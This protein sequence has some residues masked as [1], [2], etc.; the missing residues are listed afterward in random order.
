M[1]LKVYTSVSGIEN[2]LKKLKEK[3]KISVGV[4]GFNYIYLDIQNHS[5]SSLSGFELSQQLVYWTKQDF[6]RIVL[7]SLEKFTQEELTEKLF[8]WVTKN[9]QKPPL[10]YTSLRTRERR[11]VP[12]SP[13]NVITGEFLKA[14]K[15]GFSK[16]PPAS[17]EHQYYMRKI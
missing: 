16:T 14:I 1:P 8:E 2:L 15:L 4:L 7:D 17:E 3:S 12:E 11:G 9:G 10:S 13:R 5:D 6:L